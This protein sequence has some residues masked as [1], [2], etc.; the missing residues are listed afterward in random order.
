MSPT[1]SKPPTKSYFGEQSPYTPSPIQV[2]RS[3]LLGSPPYSWSS[4]DS[5][6][7][8]MHP[9][10]PTAVKPVVNPHESPSTPKYNR[11]SIASRTMPIS[12]SNSPS[13]RPRMQ[14]PP[15]GSG[16]GLR[17][18]SAYSSPRDSDTWQDEDAR[19]VM[20]SVNASR[21]LNRQS[22]VLSPYKDDEVAVDAQPASSTHPFSSSANME[23]PQNVGLENMQR[24]PTALFDSDDQEFQNSRLK[25][26][27]SQTTPRAKQSYSIQQPESSLFES[28]TASSRFA[29]SQRPQILSA[30]AQV[31][32]QNKVMTTAQFNEYK[33]EQEMTR[34]KSNAST[35]G[36]SD[37]EN[38]NYEDEDE[39][40]RNK[41][42]ARQRR[43][44]EAHLAVYRQQMMKMTG[45]Q[46]SELPFTGQ[47]RP[48]MD[49]ASAS[50]PDLTGRYATP[51]FSFDKPPNK[52]KGSDDE[53]EDVPL[54]ILAA[55]GFPSK[56]RPPSVFGSGG[57]N[58]NIK[59]TSE[60]YPAPP[61]STAGTSNA[62][63]GK[64]LPPF[65]RKLPPDPYYGAGIVN[66]SNREPPAFGTNNGVPAYGGYS[67]NPGGLV[68]VIAV[69]ERARAMRRGSPNSQGHYGH[70]LPQGMPQAQMGMP[71]GM[72]PMPMMTPGDEAQ[73]QISQQVSQMMQMQMQWMQEMQQMVSGA[74][75]G[76]KFGP[77][78]GQ[79]PQ[80]MQPQQQ[81]MAG[82]GFLSPPGQLSRPM[83][84]LSHSAPDTPTMGSQPQQ[85]TMS[86]MTPSTG[87][88]WLSNGNVRLTA[89]SIMSGGLGGQGYAPSIAPSERSNVGMPS[90][91]RPVS[92]APMDEAPRPGS[93]ASTLFSGALQIGNNRQSTLGATIR[94]VPSSRQKGQTISDDDDDEGWE[95]MKKNREKK[96]SSWRTKRN[97]DH[98]IHEIYYPE[99]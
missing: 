2:D 96:K 51:S 80:L 31:G 22:G 27:S 42:L 92:I 53:D 94:P 74:T 72:M 73:I 95:E 45:E 59:Y 88:Q 37:E 25:L 62:A 81:Q 21:R 85:R 26:E 4:Q 71:P 47:T 75:Q 48:G 60:S 76:Q 32:G 66:P 69:E 54:G 3:R 57:S 61:M 98:A 38:D 9:S 93:R 17:R 41:Q 44:Q 19:L 39:S 24:S 5:Q 82:H 43:K 34:S 35:S 70:P 56:N 78:P 33:K 89:P 13:H 36:D 77:Q 65:A 99:E 15:S 28:S 68:G 16:A 83:S 18:S 86:M 90:R 14:R 79:Q 40:E 1:S 10:S 87:P 97:D 55:H 12:V 23:A 91:Y 8:L 49:R 64:G 50:T 30:Q 29:L 7:S 63:T 84:T 67:P 11:I 46:P 58:P 52:S 20:D 6:D